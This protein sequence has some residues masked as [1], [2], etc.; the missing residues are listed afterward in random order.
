VYYQTLV[1]LFM[2]S[3]SSDGT[4]TV[5][6]ATP[7][8]EALSNITFREFAGFV[9]DNFSSTVS[10]ATVLV[11]LFTISDNSDAQFHSRMQHPKMGERGQTITGWIK[12]L[13]PAL[14]ENLA[15]TIQRDFSN[16]LKRCLIMTLN[17]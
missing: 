8:H 15:K 4:Y 7:N 14:S 5:V 11:M 13:A 17:D 3:S 12:A 16:N 9:E 2:V 6:S 1:D 10:L